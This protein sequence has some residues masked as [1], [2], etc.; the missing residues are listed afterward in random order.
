MSL[1]FQNSTRIGGHF[2]PMKHNMV[3]ARPSKACASRFRSCLALIVAS[4]FLVFVW[5]E[6]V[7]TERQLEG[8]AIEV[9]LDLDKA[10]VENANQLQIVE[11]DA[12]DETNTAR[13]TKKLDEVPYRREDVIFGHIHMARTAG[14]ALN[15]KLSNH[16]ERVCGNKGYSYDAYV[17]GMDSKNPDVV[18]S[19]GFED[20]DYISMETSP[21]NSDFWLLFDDFHD[22]PME[23]HVPCREPIDYLMSLCHYE[24]VRGRAEEFDCAGITSDED[25]VDAVNTCLRFIDRFDDKLTKLE[26][27]RVKCYDF[28]H[29]FTSYIDYMKTKLQARRF[30]SEP[31]KQ[32]L[33]TPWPRH[34]DK[35]CIWKDEALKER[36][37]NYLVKEVPYFRYCKACV[38]S[39]N[40]VTRPAG[41]EENEIGVS[42]E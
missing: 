19:I 35:E 27:V 12:D 1:S 26:H 38:G 32:P 8:I 21:T 41:V 11:Q 39:E 20:C 6:E 16:F 22:T 33:K 5:N 3:A 9:A 25:M 31:K 23:L 18:K 34:K 24:K 37:E 14:S 2:L 15:W 17:K 7:Q 36:V 29:Q 42:T 10:N 4:L 13:R 28:K 40:D 30:V